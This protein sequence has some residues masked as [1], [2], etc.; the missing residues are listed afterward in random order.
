VS[1][2]LPDA[3]NRLIEAHRRGAH[4][5][6]LFDYDGTLVSIAEHPRMALLSAAGRHQLTRLAAIPSV[7]VGVLSG[8]T[9]DD[10]RRCVRLDGLFYVGTSGLELAFGD[11]TTTHPESG[12]IAIDVATAADAVRRALPD[13]EAAWIELKPFGLTVHYRGV[14]ASRID[15]LRHDVM[16]AIAPLERSFRV[17]DGPMAIEITPDLGWTKESALRRILAHLG[18]NQ[19]LPFY[20]GDDANDADALA[21]AVSLGGIAVGIGARAPAAAQYRLPDPASLGHFLDHLLQHLV[22]AAQLK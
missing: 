15:T 5:L 8:R 1:A 2:A 17:L 14:S 22:E 4:L 18:R 3:L 19:V 21:A 9:I 12:R 13:D 10:L 6:L 11:K 16:R 20:A 7:S